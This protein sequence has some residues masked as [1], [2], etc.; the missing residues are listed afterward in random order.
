MW[1]IDVSL[2]ARGY[3]ALACFATSCAI[4]AGLFFWQGW[5][6]LDLS[7]EGFLWY[8][9]QRV[10]AGEVPLRD[11]QSYDPG[12]YYWS[13][14]IM[15]LKGD[16]G[17]VAL[18]AAIAAC[19]VVGLTIGLWLISG[20]KRRLDVLRIILAAATLSVGICLSRM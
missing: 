2:Q 16:G 3:R 14:A 5:Q 8:G 19:R 15:A 10:I 7:D 20:R 11:F 12:R 18:R 17:I 6:D 4:V 1:R 13:A 9:V